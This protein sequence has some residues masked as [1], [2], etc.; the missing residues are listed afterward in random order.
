MSKEKTK[1]IEVQQWYKCYIFNHLAEDC[2]NKLACNKCGD[3]HERKKCQATGNKFTSCD[4]GHSPSYRGSKV[5]SKKAQL[6]RGARKAETAKLPPP[7]AEVK[8]K[9]QEVN[10]KC[11]IERLGEDACTTALFH[12]SVDVLS[13]G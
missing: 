10:G 3:K 13:Q 12:L 4:E 5:R 9:M 6:E 8:N 1:T 11:Y 7:R 2:Q